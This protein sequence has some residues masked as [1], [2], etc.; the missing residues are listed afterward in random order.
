MQISGE[1]GTELLLRYSEEELRRQLEF[2]RVAEE[3]AGESR[4]DAGVASVVRPSRLT[5]FVR[6]LVRED[7][8]A[9]GPEWIRPVQGSSA[10]PEP[11]LPPARVEA[12]PSV[13]SVGAESSAERDDE[14]MP[15]MAGSRR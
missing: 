8:A 2:R 6:F 1:Y 15:V 10:T 3:R 4:G 12:G 7:T 14:R 9:G 5:R 11:V 13:T